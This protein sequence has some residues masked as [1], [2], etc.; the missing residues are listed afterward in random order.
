VDAEDASGPV[1][2]EAMPKC[3]G[4]GVTLPSSYKRIEDI[5]LNKYLVNIKPQAS[6][7]PRQPRGKSVVGL[8]ASNAYLE[9]YVGVYTPILSSPYF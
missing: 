9:S 6:G 5:P 4:L 1:M 8:V 7:A 2:P 3:A